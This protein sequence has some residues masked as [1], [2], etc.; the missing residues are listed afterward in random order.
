MCMVKDNLFVLNEIV[1]FCCNCARSVF[2]ELKSGSVSLVLF[3]FLFILR[4]NG[5]FNHINLYLFKKQ[6]HS[7]PIHFARYSHV[8]LPLCLPKDNHLSYDKIVLYNS[9]PSFPSCTTVPFQS[10]CV[11][12]VFQPRGK[13]CN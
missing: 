13:V 8:P 10:P 1:F 12:R 3:V 11:L 6:K 7:K 4:Q 9:L 5:L 2:E